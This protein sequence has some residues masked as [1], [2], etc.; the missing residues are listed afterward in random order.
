MRLNFY[1]KRGTVAVDV[2]TAVIAYV[3]FNCHRLRFATGISIAKKNWN[4]DKQRAKRGYLHETP[5][6]SRLESL[7]ATI[8]AEFVRLQ[9]ESGRVDP[10]I[11]T[12]RC[13]ELLSTTKPVTRDL[14]QCFDDFIAGAKDRLRPASIKTYNTVR[15]HVKGFND[16]YGLT[17]TFERIDRLFLERFIG[18][19]LKVVQLNNSSAQKV[20]TILGTFLRWA[21]EQGLTESTEFR[22]FTRKAVPVGGEKSDQVYLTV[23][24]LDKL[25]NL[26]LSKRPHF[27][28]VRDLFILQAHTGLRYGDIQQ[29]GPEHIQ[30]G[31]IR[32]VT[33]KNRK[34]IVI[35]FL[36]A[37]RAIWQKYDGK[38]P[39]IS[40]Q[41]QNESLKDLGELAGLDT[42]V[43]VVDYR[44]I[45]RIEKVEPKHKLIGTHT[46][47]RSF[48][49]VL[50]QRGVSVEAIMKATGNNRR[51]IER[52]IVATEHDAVSEIVAAWGKGERAKD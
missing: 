34:A 12:Q 25:M 19:L 37:A 17:V 32:L 1:L 42:P 13:K 51:T 41:K 5:I 46:A 15:G 3:R 52:Y 11:F 14:L 9:H 49:T 28:R 48:V 27:D 38:L 4:A 2:E 29:L 39:R 33:G 50:R 8:T 23:S 43:V 20:V 40:N 24:E 16:S 7:A 44:G 18:Y 6:N 35:P 36:P 10:E 30:E 21:H 22:R 26:D 47:K 31:N 45:E